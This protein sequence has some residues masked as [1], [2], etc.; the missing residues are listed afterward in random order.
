VDDT[1][2]E[3]HDGS[4]VDWA[5]AGLDMSAA[6]GP[7]GFPR[8]SYLAW[9][10]R[11]PSTWQ[12]W[13]SVPW[14]VVV[15][16]CAAAD[17]GAVRQGHVDEWSRSAFLPFGATQAPIAIGPDGTLAVAY[18]FEPAGFTSAQ[19]ELVG[20]RLA[21]C[22]AAVCGVDAVAAIG[23]PDHTPPTVSRPT[24]SL[25]S[26]DALV[27]AAIRVRLT[28]TGA[29]AESGIATYQVARSVDAGSTW[30][31]VSSEVHSPK[32]VTT[33]EP[34]RTTR[35][36]VRA[37]DRGGNVG[38]WAE[39]QPIEPLLFQQSSNAL[40]YEGRW[41]RAES[42]RFSGGSARFSSA[43]GASVR[44]TQ[45]ARAIALVTTTAPNRGRMAVHVDGRR[46]ATLDLRS[47]VRHDRVLVWQRTWT[48][49]KARTVRFAILGTPGRPRI[50]LDA[51]VT[52][53]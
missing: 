15:A 11:P 46:V 51:I 47:A 8:V 16:A 42:S 26:G 50:D 34:G 18:G 29:D 20:V 32:L 27:G 14:V 19:P 13:G 7:D 6:L 52:V 53:R 48:T 38:S 2:V 22:A 36:R 5:V 4:E 9:R 24:V 28:W 17:C 44:I 45:S 41:K 1:H 12:T 49:A 30:T 31:I 37:V 3:E 43:P 39:S 10:Q 21:T 35:F 40:R 23:P 33:A 25:L